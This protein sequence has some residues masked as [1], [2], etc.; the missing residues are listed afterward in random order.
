MR[1]IS[2]QLI[3]HYNS[4]PEQ[5]ILHFQKSGFPDK[6][7]TYRQLLHGSIPYA[8]ALKKKR[9]LP[10]D[11]VVIILQHS[12]DLIFSYFGC[13]LAGTIPSIMPFLTE[14]LRPEKYRSDLMSLIEITQ[15]AAVIAYKDFYNEISYLENS[16][17]SVRSIL[18]CETIEETLRSNLKN[19]DFSGQLRNP[20]DIVLLQHSSGTT[21][22]Q[23][24]V[25]LSH[26]A[27]INQIDSYGKAIR[28]SKKDVIVSW[29]P[30]YHDMGLI[31]SFLMPI[32]FGTPLVLM[33]PF[34]W[35]RAPYKLLQSIDAYQ[36]TLTWL[37][38]FAFNFCAQ[39]IQ[40]RDL[41]GLDLSALRAVI[42][43]SEPMRFESH[44]MF[45]DRFKPYGFK[46]SALATSYAL[47][48]NVFAVTQGGID[49]PIIY[50]D[51]SLEKLQVEKKAEPSNQNELSVI[52]V[53]AGRKIEG[54]EIKI[55]D[56]KGISLKNRV[57]GEIFIKGNCMLTGYFNREDATQ[58]AINDGWFAT[59]D[60]GY[61]AKDELFITGRKKDL[62]IV[63]GK[64]IYPQDIETI[65][66]GIVGVHPGRTVAF[67]VFNQKKGTE[68]VVVI[69]EI[70]PGYK[71]EIKVIANN[72]RKSVSQSTA[73]V[74]SN[75]HLVPEKWLIKTSSGKIA[76]SAN[77][78]KFLLE[79]NIS[80]K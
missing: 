36:G 45:F 4:R 41:E 26:E 75:I 57:V 71:Q 1:N 43:C 56:E 5:V 2:E 69:A 18:L 78:E 46:E 10:G 9:V 65:I 70:E 49:E 58:K 31:A 59:G 80:K 37:P 62:I 60:L 72:I 16:N 25:A 24:G 11:V 54:T 34:D 35:V 13:I 12:L 8:D 7:I 20:E 29:L 14:K 32:L 33:S 55:V 30:L 21:G 68:D 51:I 63:G 77:K 61:M 42:N 3:T 47:A 76:R 28:L 39:K 53:S 48:E 66:S 15:P 17:S 38:N 19:C 79:V 23:K 74:L 73:V 40:S 50:E 6:H 44:M 27:I 67:G 64:N 52:M 22:L